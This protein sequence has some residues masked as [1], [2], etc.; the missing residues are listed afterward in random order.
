V[1]RVKGLNLAQD[2]RF[3]FGPCRD[4]PIYKLTLTVLFPPLRLGLKPQQEGTRL[5][6]GGHR[7]YPVS[8]DLAQREV[9]VIRP[10]RGQRLRQTLPKLSSC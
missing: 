3:L 9:H 10:R 6:Q 8:I 5:R 2:L 7:S 1:L 4:E